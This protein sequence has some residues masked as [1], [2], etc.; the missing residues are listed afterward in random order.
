MASSTIFILSALFSL[1]LG[2]YVAPGT[3]SKFH[4]VI[5]LS[6]LQSPESNTVAVKP[7]DVAEWFF[8]LQDSTYMQFQMNGEGYRSEL[9]QM[10]SDEDEAEWSV[11]GSQTMSAEIALPTPEPAM[12]EFTFMQVHCGVKPALRVG[13]FKEFDGQT[14][15]LVATLRLNAEDDGDFEKYYLGQRSS[16]TTAYEVKVE[17]S[18]IS[19]S[20]GGV[21]VRS[22]MDVS[23]WDS[24]DCYF[25]AGVYIQSQSDDSTIARTKF[26]ELIWPSV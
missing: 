19:V 17:G 25:K 24:Y 23:F 26:R 3:L 6:K 20:I 5:E 13:W 14:D 22:D 4:P 7:Y 12:E 18:K 8:H 10:T 16:D 21:T 2:Q 15:A 1:A 11:T 9:R